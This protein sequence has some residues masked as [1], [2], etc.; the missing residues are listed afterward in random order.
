M[1]WSLYSD[2]CNENVTTLSWSPYSAKFNAVKY[3]QYCC[4]STICKPNQFINTLQY[5]QWTTIAAY[6]HIIPTYLRTKLNARFSLLSNRQTKHYFANAWSLLNISIAIE[7]LEYFILSISNKITTL[8]YKNYAK[9][10]HEKDATEKL[11]AKIKA[12]ETTDTTTTMYNILEKE[13]TMSSP[14]M[15]DFIRTQVQKGIATYVNKSNSQN[16]SGN[17]PNNNNNN[18]NNTQ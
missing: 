5:F 8:I 13:D 4:C 2:Q 11:R 6:L 17:H 10:Q 7:K 15:I 14:K 18:N 12:Q 9:S 3:T 1:S 16:V